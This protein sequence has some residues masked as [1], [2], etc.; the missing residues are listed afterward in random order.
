[1]QEEMDGTV[2]SWH[3]P[4]SCAETVITVPIRTNLI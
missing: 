2:S 1:M 4:Y 3:C